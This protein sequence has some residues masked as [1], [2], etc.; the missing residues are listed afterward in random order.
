MKL[1]V[2]RVGFVIPAQPIMASSGSGNTAP[3]PGSVALQHDNIAR[4]PAGKERPDQ[5]HGDRLVA[6]WTLIP[7]QAVGEPT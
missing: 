7:F 1:K 4:N 6:L 3:S 2:F 5:L